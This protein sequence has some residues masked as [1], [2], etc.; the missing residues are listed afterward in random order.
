M[1]A[2]KRTTRRGDVIFTGGTVR[3]QIALDATR[4][5]EEKADPVLVSK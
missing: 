4:R 1:S 3:G 5:R 2:R